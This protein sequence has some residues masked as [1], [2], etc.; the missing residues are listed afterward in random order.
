MQTSLN[1]SHP[2][3]SIA[4]HTLY[5][6][7][8]SEKMVNSHKKVMAHFEIPVNY[9]N[10]RVN[11]GTW[12]G[13][14]LERSNSDFVCFFDTDCVPI[15]IEGLQNSIKEAI[16]L[17]TFVGI[18]QASNH[19]HGFTHHIFA[20]P[21]F[22]IVKREIYEQFGK[23]N[24]MGTPRSDAAQEL[25]HIADEKNIKYGLIYPTH[26]EHGPKETGGKPWNLGNYGVYGIGTTYG[27]VCYHLYQGRFEH[28]VTLF[29]KRCEEIIN[30]EFSTDGMHPCKNEER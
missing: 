23:P 11:H 30:N 28:N 6:P 9:T 22:L 1:P 5:Y 21:G 7:N 15:T 12:L 2:N 19:I 8:M 10:E 25:S 14:V 29:E 20:A 13:R 16:N 24:M 18:A 3:Y 27:N 26:Y 17:Q 4:F